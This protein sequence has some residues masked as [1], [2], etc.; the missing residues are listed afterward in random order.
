MLST[1][2]LPEIVAEPEDVIRYTCL[3]VFPRVER[4]MTADWAHEQ[5]ANPLCPGIFRSLPLNSPSPP[6]AHVP[7]ARQLATNDPLVNPFLAA[8]IAP[9]HYR[10]MLP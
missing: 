3:L 5:R 9:V 7:R 6:L 8:T 4:C 10:R 2:R 1:L